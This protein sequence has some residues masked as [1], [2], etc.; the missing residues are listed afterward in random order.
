MAQ[1][2]KSIL[3]EATNPCGQYYLH[4]DCFKVT[5]NDTH[6]A[7]GHGWTLASIQH[8]SAVLTLVFWGDLQQSSPG[9]TVSSLSFHLDIHPE[10][11]DGSTLSF[12]TATI[13]ILSNL[14][15]KQ[16]ETGLTSDKWTLCLGFQKIH[17]L[18]GSVESGISQSSVTV[19]TVTS[20]SAINTMDV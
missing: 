12:P 14:K 8:I 20:D 7:F 1:Y 2:F 16:S 9:L 10:L 6:K 13:H 3:L 11:G 4:K 18:Y 19:K 5:W 17:E 15:T